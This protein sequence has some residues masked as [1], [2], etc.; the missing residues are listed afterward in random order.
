M[1][2]VEDVQGSKMYVDRG[3]ILNLEANRVHE[4]SE[5]AYIRNVIKEGDIAIDV[6]AH[7]GYFTL[8]FSKLVGAKGSVFVFEPEPSSFGILQKN[9]DINMY[10][11]IH[12]INKAITDKTGDKIKLYLSEGNLGDHRTYDSHDNRKFVEVETIKLDDYVSDCISKDDI[13]KISFIK[14][15]TQGAEVGVIEGASNILTNNKNIKVMVE[16]WPLGLSLSGNS[17]EK[18]LDILTNRFGFKLYYTINGRELIHITIDYLIET[19]GPDS[20]SYINLIC[21]R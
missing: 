7:I 1:K 14:I 19:Y 5:T 21:M 2:L 18:L 9:K 15:D 16:F 6:G 11:N 4:S 8:I 17:R 13:D 3:D 10:S 20:V 12:L